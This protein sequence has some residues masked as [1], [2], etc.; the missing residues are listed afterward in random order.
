VPTKVASTRAASAAGT[1]LE[2]D[3]AGWN[4]VAFADGGKMLLTGV[5]NSNGEVR[6][7]DLGGAT[8]AHNPVLPG[9]A[10]TVLEVHGRLD[11][12][13]DLL[14]TVDYRIAGMVG[15]DCVIVARLKDVAGKPIP[16][17]PG[18]QKGSDG[19]MVL[20]AVVRP[21]ADPMNAYL[22]MRLPR[23]VVP[24]GAINADVNIAAGGRWLAD[25]SLSG[26]VKA[27]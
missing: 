13:G 3:A 16:A 23:A 18:A 6:R 1:A 5:V 7:W 9:G 27:K 20:T 21:V 19:G 25:K 4:F 17:P 12:A 2:R 24:A 22:V 26:Q 11:L 14:V 8:A 15:K 10:T